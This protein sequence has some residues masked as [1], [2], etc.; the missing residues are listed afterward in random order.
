MRT[1]EIGR[2]EWKVSELGRMILLKKYMSVNTE[3]CIGCSLL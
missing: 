2:D 1:G 3:V